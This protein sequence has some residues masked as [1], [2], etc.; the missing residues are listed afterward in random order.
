M[1]P[2][3]R[4]RTQY[5]LPGFGRAIG[6]PSTI[7]TDP[8]PKLPSYARRGVRVTC[9][10]IA[11]RRSLTLNFSTWAA[12]KLGLGDWELSLI[13]RQKRLGIRRADVVRAG[14]DQAVVGVLLE[15]VRRPARDAADGED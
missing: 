12:W 7:P 1:G 9:R 14:T 2:R 3:L 5:A 13:Q 8:I 4:A 15:A 11:D 6:R 10:C